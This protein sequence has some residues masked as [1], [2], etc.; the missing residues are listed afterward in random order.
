MD[1]QGREAAGWEGESGRAEQQQNRERSLME[2]CEILFQ[3]RT[4][5]SAKCPKLPGYEENLWSAKVEVG[6]ESQTSDCVFPMSTGWLVWMSHRK[7]RENKIQLMLWPDLALLGCILVSLHILCGILK[8]H[9]VDV[10]QLDFVLLI[11]EIGL[12]IR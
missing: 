5:H 7:W 3:E 6:V 4:T 12:F 1:A 10:R 9:S 2:C 8:N 11:V